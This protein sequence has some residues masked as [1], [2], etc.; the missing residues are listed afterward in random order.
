MQCILMDQGY[1]IS[2]SNCRDKEGGIDVGL[3]LDKSRMNSFTKI[4]EEQL[5]IMAC[6][7][8]SIDLCHSAFRILATMVFFPPS[9][10]P[11]FGQLIAGFPCF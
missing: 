3:A 4:L 2:L 11:I 1:I 5:N 6:E 8:W 9:M 7:E 10:V